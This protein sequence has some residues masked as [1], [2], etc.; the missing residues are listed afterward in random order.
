MLFGCCFF[1]LSS[2]LIRFFVVGFEFLLPQPPFLLLP[3]LTPPPPT[4]GVEVLGGEERG[5]LRT[6]RTGP[7]RKGDSSLNCWKPTGSSGKNRIWGGH[8]GGTAHLGAPGQSQAEG[9]GREGPRRQEAGSCLWRV[10]GSVLVTCWL[11]FW[12]E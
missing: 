12:Q 10:E 3:F 11:T 6:F 8:R 9:G 5:E 2:F 4:L 7:W 1:F